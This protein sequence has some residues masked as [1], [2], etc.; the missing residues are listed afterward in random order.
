MLRITVRQKADLTE[1]MLEGKLAG[2]WVNELRTVWADVRSWTPEEHLLVRLTDV[3][4]I[5][6]A[7]RSLLSEMYSA[8]SV[9]TGTG[10]FARTLITDI[11]ETPS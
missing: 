7:G 8:G 10:L 11:T 6:M 9:L 2:D 5:D 4:G 3:S 1:L